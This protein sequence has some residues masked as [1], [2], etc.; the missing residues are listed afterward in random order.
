MYV[1]NGFGQTLIHRVISQDEKLVLEDEIL[2]ILGLEDRPKKISTN[3]QVKRS[4]PQFLMNIYETSFTN[5]VEENKLNDNLS[6]LSNG[7]NLT[8]QSL[9]TIDESDSIITFTAHSE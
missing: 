2:N 1:D 6:N 5:E 7:F 9:K 8:E 4:A 3:T